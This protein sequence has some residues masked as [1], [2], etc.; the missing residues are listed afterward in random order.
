MVDDRD[1]LIE[2]LQDKVAVLE[3]RAKDLEAARDAMKSAAVDAAGTAQIAI[4]RLIELKE[5][6]DA[7]VVWS[8]ASEPYARSRA[9]YDL[10]SLINRY[11]VGLGTKS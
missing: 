1:K 5:I 7:V 6:A 3:Q 4:E 8:D 2:E 11:K 10:W 9:E